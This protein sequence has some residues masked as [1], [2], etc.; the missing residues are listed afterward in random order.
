MSWCINKQLYQGVKCK[1]LC[2]VLWTGYC[3]MKETFTMRWC[4]LY[5]HCYITLELQ[6]LLYCCTCRTLQTLLHCLEITNIAVPAG[7]YKHSSTDSE[8]QNNCYSIYL[9]DL[10]NIVTLCLYGFVNIYTTY[11]HEHKYGLM[12]IIFHEIM[13]VVAR[14]EC[15]NKLS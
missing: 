14:L 9:R 11:L 15:Y 6:T 12:K 4:L 8:L 10:A 13:T 7:L 5:E 2:A 3:A 1:A